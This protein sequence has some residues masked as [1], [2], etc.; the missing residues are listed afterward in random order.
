MANNPPPGGGYPPPGYPPGGQYGQPGPGQPMG[1]PG[2]QYGQPGAGQPMGQPGG[3]GQPGAGQPMGQPGGYGQPGAGQPMGQP[4]GY[5][6]PGAG[7]PGQYGQ[8]GMGQ[9]GMGQP[10]GQ[11][12]QYGQPGMGQ[13]PGMPPGMGQPGMGGPPPQM[14]PP[15]VTSG[16]PGFN[17][18]VGGFNIGL[19]GGMSK[20]K[21]IGGAIVTVVVLLGAGIFGWY[22]YSHPTFY[23]FN[24]TGKDGM[25]VTIDG[26]VMVSGLKSSLSETSSAAESKMLGSG[27]HKIEAKDASGKV[28]ESLEVEIESGSNGYLFAPAATKTC[29]SWCKKTRTARPRSSRRTCSSIRRNRS[30]R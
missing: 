12:G 27:K 9:P 2:G 22:S 7:Q 25:T 4:G 15:V 1:Q 14:P 13:Q 23:V 26:E 20:W 11:P 30:G 17:V 6:Q 3:Y 10:M 21:I 19:G 18:N 28:I 8:P 29:A 5:G 24:A 16:S